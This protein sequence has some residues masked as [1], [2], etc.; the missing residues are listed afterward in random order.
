MAQDSWPSPDHNDRAV[1][2]AEYEVIAARF[3]DDGVYGGPADTQIVAAGAGL[4]VTIRANAEASVRGHA[5]TSG[6]TTITLPVNANAAG[7]ARTDRVVLRLDRS[8]WTVRAVVKQGTPGS[9]APTLTQDPGDTGVY[10]IPLAL[11]TILPAAVTVTVTR[12]ELYAGARI[13]PALSTARNPV[14]VPGEMVYETDTR[15]VRVWTGSTWM[16]VS[17]DSGTVVVDSPL[18]GW[19]IG[20]T[21]VLE[22]RSGVVSLRLGSFTRAAGALAN[23]TSSRLPAVIPAAYRHPNRDQYVLVYITGARIGRITI[24]SKASDTPGQVWL[25]Q[26]PGVSTDWNVLS[27]SGTSWVV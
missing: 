2:D 10:E 3:S 7:S 27:N 22:M 26:H 25:T 20:T 11:V 8:V 1:T 5:W 12:S 14:A 9:G 24:Y 19:T 17:A 13:R 21:S 18:Y 23:T 16:I 6:A 4:N 15:Q